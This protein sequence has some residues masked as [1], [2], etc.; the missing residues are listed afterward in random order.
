MTAVCDEQMNLMM[1][2][3]VGRQDE[4]ASVSGQQRVLT[5]TKKYVDNTPFHGFT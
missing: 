5:T 3:M 1:K 4:D 2:R